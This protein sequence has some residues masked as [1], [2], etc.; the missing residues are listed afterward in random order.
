MSQSQ[1][2]PPHIHPLTRD[3]QRF[4]ATRLPTDGANALHHVKTT[5]AAHDYLFLATHRAAIEQELKDLLA[6]L[7]RQTLK[8][9]AQWLHAYYCCTLLAIYYDKKHYDS[10]AQ[11][12][13]YSA[14]AAEIAEYYLTGQFP[15]R[16]SASDKSLPIKVR[17][18]FYDALS[19]PLHLSKLRS[20]VGA[21]NMDRLA[22]TFSRI[23]IQQFLAILQA[24]HALSQLS[25]LFKITLDLEAMNARLNLSANL[26]RP[27]SVGFFVARF[28]ITMSLIMKHTFFP[29]E[30]EKTITAAK[31]FYLEIQ[32]RYAIISNDVL[33]TIFNLLTNYAPLFKITAP[34]ANTILITGLIFDASLLAWQLYK[35]EQHYT[36][37][38]NQYIHEQKIAQASLDALLDDTD[39][40]AQTKRAALLKIIAGLNQQIIQLDIDRKKLRATFSA[41]IIAASMLMCG[42][43]ASLLFALPALVLAS[44]LLIVLGIALYFSA[45]AYGAYKEKCL[46]QHRKTLLGDENAI[47]TA[48]IETQLAR[49]ALI[50]SLLKNTLV[51]LIFMGALAIGWQVAL[52]AAVLYLS[53]EAVR[54]CM[55]SKKP[56]ELK[57]SVLFMPTQPEIKQLS[58]HGAKADRFSEEPEAAQQRLGL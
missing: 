45:S 9:D 4:F 58:T 42:Y 25:R 52:L 17:D 16:T 29:T 26:F 18:D 39:L 5:A 56:P 48:R 19:T 49:N 43:T 6:S 54:Y 47:A 46:I 51:P 12:K 44:Y 15:K 50:G 38:H 2:S 28:A 13:E 35:S 10:P 55:A 31:R 21:R 33:W 24:E 57:K 40:S 8:P 32:K 36:A 34:I 20:W 23:S 11:Q 7:P 14:Q 3:K 41:N 30:E 53:V 22:Y 1:L 37:K 27:L